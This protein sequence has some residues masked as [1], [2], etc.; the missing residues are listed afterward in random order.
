MAKFKLSP[1]LLSICFLAPALSC[2]LLSARKIQVPAPSFAR[3]PF[4]ICSLP[5]AIALFCLVSRNAQ[6]L[7]QRKLQPGHFAMIFFVI[8]AQQVQNAVQDKPSDLVQG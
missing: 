7:P 6:P 5:F 3:I 2:H 4:A 1:A 8:V